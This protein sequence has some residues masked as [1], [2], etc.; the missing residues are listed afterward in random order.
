MRHTRLP[1][2]ASRA[3]GFRGDRADPLLVPPI[4]LTLGAVLAINAGRL[5]L[6]L[7]RAIRRH[8][9]GFL[10]IAAVLTVWG[11]LGSTRL[12][13]ALASLGI[14]LTLWFL[15]HEAS[16]VRWV[17]RP[18]LTGLRM[19]WRYR[20]VWSSVMSA[21]GLTTTH[22]DSEFVPTLK[23]ARRGI[24]GDQLLVRLLSGQ[25]PAD[26]ENKIDALAHTFRAETCRI[27]VNR[28]GEIW[29]DLTDTDPL[30]HPVFLSP[31]ATEPN[32]K[33]LPIGV[34]E[35]GHTWLLR[36]LGTHVLIGGATDSGKGSV[37]YSIVHAL[38]G[39]II[40]GSVRIWAID[41][42]GGMELAF[43]SG[44]FDR[45]A[46]RTSDDMLLLLEDAVAVMR[47]RQ[48]WLL[49]KTRCHTPTATDPLLVVM[50]DELA[51]LVAYTDRETRRKAVE[52]LQL[53]LSQGRAVGI[54][55]VAALQDPSKEVL[56]FRDLF[57]TR[58]ALR[59]IEAVQV[60]MILAKGARDRGAVCD[61]ISPSTP[62]VGYVQL[63]GVREPVR[64]RAFWVTD[65]D[66]AAMCAA[67]MINTLNTDP[68]EPGTVIEIEP[69]N[70]A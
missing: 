70:A 7:A 57:P 3:Y 35:D 16:F 45:L 41:P 49:G 47:S 21:S 38:L 48:A 10:A 61:A 4:R 51:A 6:L 9:R 11:L 60:D 63:D 20:R 50:V 56:P 44:L 23:K 52:Y 37:L 26:W 29:L 39:G 2:G 69:P 66:I 32:L 36:L 64:V 24:C 28:P 22:R 8:P 55:V 1:S 19:W 12:A 14:A 27:R 65:D 53:L 54:V 40:N 5:L 15:V 18:L 46:Y 62:G 58:I 67:R 13:I 43:A 17:C 31:A 42:K 30:Q 25:S 59:L 34:Q 68:Y 33:A